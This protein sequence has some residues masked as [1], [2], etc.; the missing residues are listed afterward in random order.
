M[1]PFETRSVTFAE[2][3]EMLYAC[4]GK[5]RRFCR[6]VGMLSA[7]LEENGCN[8][9]VL[10]SIRSIRQYFDVA[11]PL[12]HQDEEN[13]FF[14]LLLRYAPQAQEGV[15]EL[16]RQHAALHDNWQAVAAEFE[17][18]EHDR[19]YRPSEKVLARFVGSYDVHLGIEEPLFELGKQ[20]VPQEEL[21]KIGE[22]M[23]ARRRPK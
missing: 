4:H 1:N 6:Q 12:H 3:I 11:A 22:R 16:L 21:A 23:A 7:Y 15:D 5:V 17:R 13:D 20:F 14:P 19:S 8:D 18:L 9:V 10:Q 2:P